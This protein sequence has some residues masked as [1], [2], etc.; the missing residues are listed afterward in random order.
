ME[1]KNQDKPEP[2]VLYIHAHDMTPIPQKELGDHT[3]TI[4]FSSPNELDQELK[5]T[6]KGFSYN[7]MIFDFHGNVL[8]RKTIFE[9][10]T[11]KKEIKVMLNEGFKHS[12][13][14]VLSSCFSGSALHNVRKKE[15][16][17]PVGGCFVAIASSKTVTYSI[18]SNFI[19]VAFAKECEVEKDPLKRIAHIALN[20][21]T[22]TLSVAYK[23]TDGVMVYFKIR[24]LKATKYTMKQSG[25]PEFDDIF[26][27][28]AEHSVMGV[29]D[30]NPLKRKPLTDIHSSAFIQVKEIVTNYIKK[31]KPSDL[32]KWTRQYCLSRIVIS[33]IH[34]DH[35]TA[36]Y[37]INLLK[38]KNISVATDYAQIQDSAHPF[39]WLVKVVKFHN[40]ELIARLL[41][42][43][44]D[45]I[46][47]ASGAARVANG[48][49]FLNIT[50]CIKDINYRPVHQLPLLHYLVEAGKNHNLEL[51]LQQRPDID[52][53]LQDHQGVT[54]LHHAVTCL[55][56]RSVEILLKY[57]ANPNSIDSFGCS[58][59]SS[60]L[61]ESDDDYTQLV[62]SL[63]KYGANPNGTMRIAHIVLDEL[64]DLTFCYLTDVINRGHEKLCG[65]LIK[66]GANIQECLNETSIQGPKAIPTLAKAIAYLIIRSLLTKKWPNV[67]DEAVE[68]LE[69]VKNIISKFIE[70]EIKDSSK[71]SL[72]FLNEAG[73]LKPLPYVEDLVCVKQDFYSKLLIDK[74]K[75]ISVLE[76][77]DQ[78][79]PFD[80]GRS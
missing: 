17:I 71:K 22:E 66:H 36:K 19:S 15:H 73:F 12:Q 48:F 42:N 46:K 4:K 68:N 43:Q 41:F 29:L 2:T 11:R 1:N 57:K 30:N 35:L 64:K 78:L 67:P 40:K 52:I 28:F 70:Q 7:A 74:D 51:F 58:A 38:N 59:L 21:P 26:D 63:L 34:Q 23:N 62:D 65:A 76:K 80:L 50:S 27:H 60:A 18:V 10:F 33:I 77:S 13:L 53:N 32:V 8:F 25:Y 24:G 61:R 54:A 72:S 37:Y 16:L 39:Y 5:N 44:D 79:T 45:A 14:V 31:N 75:I 20:H 3:K 56:G 55:Q 47:L 49:D 69:E 6:G 9:S